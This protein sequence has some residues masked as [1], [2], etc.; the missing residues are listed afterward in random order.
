ML[1]IVF[2]YVTNGGSG[3]VDIGRALILIQSP[4]V[5]CGHFLRQALYFI[6]IGYKKSP[7]VAVGDHGLGDGG[8]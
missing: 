5:L 3:G 2:F 1:G 4:A 6:L 7:T 8:L